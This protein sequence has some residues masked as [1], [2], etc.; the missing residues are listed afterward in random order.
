MTP[1]I[2]IP[3][4]LFATQEHRA[5]LDRLGDS[6]QETGKGVSYRLLQ[7]GRRYVC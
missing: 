5:R 4:D 6:Q 1:R 2:A 3:P 7:S